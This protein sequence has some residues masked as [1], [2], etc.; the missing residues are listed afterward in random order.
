MRAMGDVETRN[1]HLIDAADIPFRCLSTLGVEAVSGRSYAGPRVA[2]SHLT[3][4]PDQAL[5]E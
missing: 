2:K 4:L 1:M 3:S 5:N